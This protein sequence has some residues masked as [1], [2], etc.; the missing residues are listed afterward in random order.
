LE[1]FF[2]SE[3]FNTQKDNLSE[4]STQQAINNSKLKEIKIHIPDDINEQKKIAEILTKVDEAIENTEALIQ[5][6]ESIKVGLMQDLLTKGID[7]NGTI[8]SEETHQFKDSPLGRIPVDWKIDSISKYAN[9]VVVGIVIKPTQYYIESGIPMLRSQNIKPGK[10]IMSDLVYMSKENNDKLKKSKLKENDIV[11]VR[12]GYPGISSVVTK[13]QE[14][15]NCIDLVITRIKTELVN[16]YYLVYFI[17][18]WLGRMQILNQ[19]SGIAQQHF[20][21][22]D[23]KKLLFFIPQF[24]E[25]NKIVNV[26]NKFS[27]KIDFFEKNKAKLLNQ[28]QGLMQDLLSGK[29]RVNY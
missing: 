13:S 12:T 3:E 14:G 17:N 22:G 18:S 16:P 28:K 11:S 9:E 19:Q 20:N 23:M 6:Y 10:I 5:K 4:G 1:Q 24:E 27:D 25:Q 21:V 26:I 2:L 8:R 29:V 7:K 15:I